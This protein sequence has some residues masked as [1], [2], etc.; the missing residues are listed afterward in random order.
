MKSHLEE[1][2]DAICGRLV[3]EAAPGTGAN[4]PQ[5]DKIQEGAQLRF[6]HI[7]SLAVNC[8]ASDRHTNEFANP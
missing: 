8:N 5:T 2:A 6:L 4:N 1:A 7:S 3:S